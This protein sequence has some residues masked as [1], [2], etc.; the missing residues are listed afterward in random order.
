MPQPKSARYSLEM[1]KGA[2]ASSS[3]ASTG[4]RRPIRLVHP[5]QAVLFG[6]LELG[7]ES[8]QLV[9][10]FSV[11]PIRLPEGIANFLILAV[12]QAL[13]SDTALA[14]GGSTVPADRQM[15]DPAPGAAS[16]SGSRVASDISRRGEVPVQQEGGEKSRGERFRADNESVETLLTN[17]L[18]SQVIGHQPKSAAESIC[19]DVSDV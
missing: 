11:P 5:V 12:A 7:F 10:A 4:F 13:A 17:V 3:V 19:D 9:A 1:Q 14:R 6:A 8:I 16:V 18:A 2:P 15:R